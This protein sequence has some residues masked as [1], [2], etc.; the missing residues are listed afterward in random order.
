M[1]ALGLNISTSEH[2][3]SELDNLIA[4]RDEKR[5]QTEGDRLT[6]DLWMPSA[7]AYRREQQRRELE[8][9]I[10]YHDAQLERHRATFGALTD[11]HERQ[12]NRRRDEL[13]RL[14]G[15]ERA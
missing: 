1:E 13:A 12:R 10:R 4:R 7:R 9:R 6:E 14:S 15:E 5:P 8:E 2:V 3:E 11:Y